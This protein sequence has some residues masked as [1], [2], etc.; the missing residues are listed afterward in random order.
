MAELK[1]ETTITNCRGCNRKF[2]SIEDVCQVFGSCGL[3]KRCHVTA[4]GVSQPHAFNDKA[5][6]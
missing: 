5:L 4:L 2:D 3:C 6:R 1:Q